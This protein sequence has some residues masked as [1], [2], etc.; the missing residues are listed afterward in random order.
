MDMN[1]SWAYMVHSSHKGIH[2]TQL[3]QGHTWYTAHTR[4]YMVHSSHKG[5]CIQLTHGHT[6]LTHRHTY[7]V[8]TWTYVHS[9]HMDI[10]TQLT[11]G[12]TYTAHTR[13]YMVHSSHMSMNSSHMDIHGTQLTHG[14]MYTA[15]TWAYMAHTQI[16]VPGT[17]TTYVVHGLYSTQD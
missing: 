1:S 5:I 2:G 8:H 10:R 3:T 15:H 12:H 16:P 4:A 11:H 13:A 6:Q 14:H 9:L 7:T 17:H